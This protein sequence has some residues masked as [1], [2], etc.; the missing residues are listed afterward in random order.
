MSDTSKPPAAS[1][2]SLVLARPLAL[3]MAEFVRI[4]LWKRD[5]L[6]ADEFFFF[7]S[8]CERAQMYCTSTTL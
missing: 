8:S 7:I 1:V 6:A 2:G 3:M 4:D 5:F